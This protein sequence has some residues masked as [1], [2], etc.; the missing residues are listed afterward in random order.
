MWI[1]LAVLAIPTSLVA[2]PALAE[3]GVHPRKPDAAALVQ[4][5]WVMVAVKHQGIVTAQIPSLAERVLDDRWYYMH[6]IPEKR[7]EA[8][9]RAIPPAL[10]PETPVYR[11]AGGRV[12]IWED[13][14]PGQEGTY[15][16]DGARRPPVLEVTWKDGFGR[17]S[18]H[19]F[20]YQF[21]DDTMAWCCDRKKEDGLPA[22]FAAKKGEHYILTFRQV[23]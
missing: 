7:N 9:L 5:D 21:S 8:A 2:T 17:L 22:E 15:R 20:L 13:L 6:V 14:R 11:F 16:F 18:V 19:R 3:R 10:P 12:T 4:G 23:K 1:R